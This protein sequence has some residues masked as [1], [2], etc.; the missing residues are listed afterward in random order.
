MKL[1]L[2]LLEL[3]PRFF[4]CTCFVRIAFLRYGIEIIELA[5]YISISIIAVLN[6]VFPRTGEANLLKKVLFIPYWLQA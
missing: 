2:Q 4:N 6:K 3:P 5:I 1:T